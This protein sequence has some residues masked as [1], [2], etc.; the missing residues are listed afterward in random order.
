VAAAASVLAPDGRITNLFGIED[1]TSIPTRK[2]KNA[3]L[4][5]KCH[6]LCTM[7]MLC[8]RLRRHEWFQH[9]SY[10]VAHDKICDFVE[11]RRFAIDN[12]ECCAAA[13]R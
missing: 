1:N 6:S 8:S 9:R 2:D 12:Y 5:Q 11:I 7:C 13:L 4:C 3:T 10:V